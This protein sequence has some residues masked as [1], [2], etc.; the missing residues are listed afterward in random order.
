M[1]HHVAPVARA[2]ADRDEQRPILRRGRARRPP[3]PTGTSR[4]DCRRAGGGTGSRTP[5]VGSC[6][7][8]TPR[9]FSPAGRCRM[10]A[11]MRRTP[12]WLVLAGGVIVV[13]GVLIQAFTI[14]AYVRGAGDGAL[15]AHGGF[16]MVVHIGQ[17]LIVIGAIWAWWGNWSAVGARRRVPRPLASRSSRSSAT[18]RSRA[19][20]STA[21]TASSRCRSSSR[22]AWYFTPARRALGLGSSEHRDL[23][24]TY[25]RRRGPSRRSPSRVARGDAA[26]ELDAR[27]DADRDREEPS[28][29]PFHGSSSNCLA[30]DVAEHRRV[31]SPERARRSRR[32]SMNRRHGIACVYPE[33]NVT[34]VRPPG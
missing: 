4:P 8:H 9:R 20:G 14:A 13:I 2:V 6:P 19:A 15:D 27:G 33:E 17:L 10:V 5:R 28:S 24:R 16:S 26:N 1:L 7:V 34:A 29:S 23:A 18:R 30:A 21:C 22:A 3:H 12:L 25:R 11:R 32:R 31:G